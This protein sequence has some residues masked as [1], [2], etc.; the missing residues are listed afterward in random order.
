MAGRQGRE[1]FRPTV[2]KGVADRDQYRTNAPLRKRYK[3]GFEIAIGSGIHNNELQAQ[4][5]C[6]RLQ[7]CNGGLGRWSGR[8]YEHAEYGSIGY[9][10]VEQLQLFRRQLGR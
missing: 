7:V 4:R 10:L 1:L 3:G 8:V 5:A 2:E 9:Q 6:R